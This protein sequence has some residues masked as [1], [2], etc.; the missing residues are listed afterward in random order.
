VLSYT[1]TLTN[2]GNYTDSF[3]LYVYGLWS[4]TLPGG[5]ST[6]PLAAG[7]S[8]KVTVNVTVPAD[9]SNGEISRTTLR[10]T[11]NLST[12]VRKSSYVTSTALV[13]APVYT[14][15]IPILRK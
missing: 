2:T 15:M 13:T 6:G 5:D 11:S 7:A 1:F 4:S 8:T 3:T 10:A 14:T 9:V 12:L